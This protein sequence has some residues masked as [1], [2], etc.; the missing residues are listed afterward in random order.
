M[1]P[2]DLSLPFL[3]HDGAFRGRLVRLPETAADILGRHDYPPAVSRLVGEAAALACAL[4]F[5]MKFDGVFT[6]QAQG[7]GPVHMLVADVT[8]AGAVR[9]C[10]RFDADAVAA[11]D[12]PTA[13]QDASVQ[14]LL[15]AGHL[16]F[17]VDQGSDTRYQGVVEL[18]GA[19]LAECVHQYFRRSE[20]L[21]TAI[22]VVADPVEAD[23]GATAWRA[24]ALM[25]QRMPATGG[26]SPS[27]LS[28]DEADD[29]WRTAV[30]LL[31]SLTRAELIEPTLAPEQVLFRLFH[32]E[33]LSVAEG[34]AL[35][36]GC[37]CS[38]DRVESTLA[39]FPASELEDMLRPDGTIGVHCQFCGTE[40]AV[41]PTDLDAL[42]EKGQD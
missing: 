20:Q 3:L 35:Q 24:A 38:R 15:G 6:L 31:G 34:R 7:S 33:H 5:S 10:A 40:Y 8:S 41:A 23:D 22:K 9:A 28:A 11:L 14:R 36:F 39:S 4:A 42:R 18:E 26:V 37:R 12:A 32:Q 29:A 21:E 13:G 16:A 30:V 1:T 17:T 25:I 2:S 27:P 19:T